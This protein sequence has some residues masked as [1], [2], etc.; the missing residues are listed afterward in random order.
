LK[1]QRFQSVKELLR[2]RAIWREKKKENEQESIH[3]SS[4][5]EQIIRFV[6]K[7]TKQ[8]RYGGCDPTN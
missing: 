7:E 1:Q 5:G 3:E 2:R 8:K 4:R 6:R